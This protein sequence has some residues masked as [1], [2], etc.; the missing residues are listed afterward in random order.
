LNNSVC[1]VNKG[2]N[3]SVEFKGLKLSISGISVVG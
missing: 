2:I 3:K 1:Q